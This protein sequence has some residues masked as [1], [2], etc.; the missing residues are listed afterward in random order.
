VQSPDGFFGGKVFFVSLDSPCYEMP[1]NTTKTEGK[2][3]KK[4]VS[5]YFFWGLRQIYVTFII[6]FFT[7]P[8]AL[9]DLLGRV[10]VGGFWCGC[11]WPV[12][13]VVSAPSPMANGL[14]M[15][16]WRR[17]GLWETTRG[18]PPPQK[19]DIKKEQAGPRGAEEKIN[20]KRRI[21]S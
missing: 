8:L 4:K 7:A 3:K 9:S 6:Y 16:I 11:S 12:R 10:V 5:D 2:L 13:P 21:S 17:E 19:N 18:A 14:K 1:K 15:C 20:S